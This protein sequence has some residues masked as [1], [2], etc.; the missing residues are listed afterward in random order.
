MELTL[1]TIVERNE[2]NFIANPIGDEIIILNM[3]TGDYLGLNSV[4]S[5][6]WEHLKSSHSVAEI[7]DLLVTEFDVDKETCLKQ[8]L[9]YLEQINAHGLL[10]VAH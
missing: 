5:A 3:E 8:T 6:I 10:Q 1:N 9:Q 4:G 2:T 7:I